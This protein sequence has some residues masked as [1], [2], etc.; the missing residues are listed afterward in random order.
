MSVAPLFHSPKG[1]RTPATPPQIAGRKGTENTLKSTRSAK[2]FVL[3]LRTC[4]T[5]SLVAQLHYA[6]LVRVTSY[7]SVFLIVGIQLLSFA[8]RS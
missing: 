8:F 5:V 7:R 2:C 4:V 1:R 6:S 3:I